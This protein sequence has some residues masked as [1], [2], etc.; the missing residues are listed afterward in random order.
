MLGELGLRVGEQELAELYRVHVSERVDGDCED[1]QVVKQRLA[2]E[3]AGRVLE[4]VGR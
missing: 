2:R 3:L 4:P 1:L